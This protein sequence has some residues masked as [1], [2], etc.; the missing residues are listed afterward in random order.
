[1]DNNARRMMR[2]ERKSKELQVRSLLAQAFKLVHAKKATNEQ[3]DE[4]RIVLEDV[5]K[6]QVSTREQVREAIERH[7]GIKPRGEGG[8]EASP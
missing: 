2:L 6:P 4:L 8:S 5:T 1:M 7:F 3:L